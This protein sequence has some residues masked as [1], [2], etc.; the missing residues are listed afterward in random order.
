MNASRPMGS[1]RVQ[2]SMGSVLSIR[3][4][5]KE[6]A[7]G[8]AGAFALADAIEQRFSAFVATSEISQLRGVAA[9]VVLPGTHRVQLLLDCL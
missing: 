4:D 8:I 2:R 5:G 7:G 9:V 6:S 1:H 3:T